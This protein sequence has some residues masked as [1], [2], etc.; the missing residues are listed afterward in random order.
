MTAR[1]RRQIQSEMRKIMSV[2]EKDSYTTR[3]AVWKKPWETMEKV[4]RYPKFTLFKAVRPKGTYYTTYLNL[5]V[6]GLFPYTCKD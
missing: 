5:Y 1:E 4:K 6:D 3:P 2:R